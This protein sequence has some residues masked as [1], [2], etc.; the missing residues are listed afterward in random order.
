MVLTCSGWVRL[1]AVTLAIGFAGLSQAKAADPLCPPQIA[2]EQRVP[3]PPTGFQAADRDKSHP[4][5]NAEF[6]DGPPEETAWLAPDTT[7]RRGKAMT[8]IWTFAGGGD[9][10]T[11]LTCAYQGTSMVLAK[12]LPDRTRRC[13]VRYDT[14]VSPPLATAV[15]CQ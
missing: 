14:S 2:V 3:D 11:W 6:S 15:L 1:C 12:R 7:Q 5:V 8:N 9:R 4:W 10:G 13:E